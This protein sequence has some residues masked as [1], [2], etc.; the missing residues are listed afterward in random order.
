MSPLHNPPVSIR[1]FL[2]IG[3]QEDGVCRREFVREPVTCDHSV[4]DCPVEH[5]GV[6]MTY[7]IQLWA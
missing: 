7:W 4:G 2:G 3:L 1:L 6:R 5:F